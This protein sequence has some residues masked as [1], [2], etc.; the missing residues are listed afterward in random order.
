MDFETVTL[1]LGVA[2]S[3]TRSVNVKVPATAYVW[4]GVGPVPPGVPSPQV[5][6]YV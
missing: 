1:R 4:L 5:Q 3:V 6:L 2:E